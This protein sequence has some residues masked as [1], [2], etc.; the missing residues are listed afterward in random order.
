MHASGLSPELAQESSLLHFIDKTVVKAAP[1][2]DARPAAAALT[3]RQI[4]IVVMV[5]VLA[6]ATAERNCV[7]CLY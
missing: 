1:S 3:P 2:K 5:F 6:V 4:V 7:V